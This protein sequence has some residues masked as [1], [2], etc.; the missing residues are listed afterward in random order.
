MWKLTFSLAYK[1]NELLGYNWCVKRSLS[2]LLWYLV[3]YIVRN[4]EFILFFRR[5]FSGA[6]SR[7][8]RLLS[9]SRSNR[10]VTDRVAYVTDRC[11]LRHC[12]ALRTWMLVRVGRVDGV[13]WFCN[14]STCTRSWRS[15]IDNV[16]PMVYPKK[17]SKTGKLWA[18]KWLR[19]TSAL[20]CACGLLLRFTGNAWR[21]S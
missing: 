5:P 12:Q 15:A 6:R 21:H 7:R 16:I 20:R 14:E 3:N 1:T 2:T 18:R 11:C 8:I 4:L 13:L 19:R 17:W 9:R 10:W